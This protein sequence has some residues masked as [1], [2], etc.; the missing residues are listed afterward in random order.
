MGSHGLTMRKGSTGVHYECG[1]G[2]LS[3]GSQPGVLITRCAMLLMRSVKGLGCGPGW[4]GR[5]CRLGP[6]GE[7]GVVLGG[8]NCE[9]VLSVKAVLGYLLGSD[10]LKTTSVQRQFWSHGSVE[11]RPVHTGKVAGSIPAGTTF[12]FLKAP[13]GYRGASVYIGCGGGVFQA[14]YDS[15]RQ[16][17]AAEISTL[18]GVIACGGKGLACRCHV[19]RGRYRRGGLGI[20]TRS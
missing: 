5:V 15:P 8:V 19:R 18:C 4:H 10:E 16:P 9:L 12:L 3:L 13:R 2:S 17:D 11:E 14:P 7:C 20:L 6:R 1:E